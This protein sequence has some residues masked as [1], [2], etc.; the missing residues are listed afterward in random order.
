[1]K[2]AF[3]RLH[4]SILLAGFT[5][6]F[7]KLILL[8][9]GL[10]VWYR[11]FFA[12]LL[13]AVLLTAAKR[14]KL[15]SMNNATTVVATGLLLMLHWVCFYGSIKYANISVGVVCFASTSF[16]TA[17]VEPLM[18]RRR[19]SFSE[20]FL[21][22]MTLVGIAL[23]FHFDTRYRFG[24]LLG[25]ISSFVIAVFTVINERLTKRYDSDT[26]ML[27]Q[28]T[29]GWLGLT[30][31]MPLYLW[32]SPVETLLPS[33]RDLIYMTAFVLFCTVLMYR[34]IHQALRSISAF[35]VNL[36]FNLEPIYT[37][38]LAILLF[39]EHRELTVW[40][41]AGLSLILLSV[42]LQMLRVAMINRNPVKPAPG[43]V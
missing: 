3:V 21:G 23:I 26:L 17:L 38:F 7:G 40:F 25:V 36:T 5:G 43:V 12:A 20:L 4:L 34:L 11:M 19:W 24:I 15:L 37:I 14:L 18:Y 33:A 32:W 10:L 2:L 8:N 39:R 27:Y 30:L 16:F 22:G 29:S 31:L 41:Y 1:M 35:T 42:A 28:F 9:E 6:V 13:M